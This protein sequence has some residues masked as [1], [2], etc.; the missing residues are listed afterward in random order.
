[1]QQDQALVKSGSKAER[2]SLSSR[3]VTKRENL[4][5]RLS[6]DA[7]AALAAAIAVSP[8]MTLIDR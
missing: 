7:A 1:M 3:D 8:V 5:Q 2:T 4:F 6:V